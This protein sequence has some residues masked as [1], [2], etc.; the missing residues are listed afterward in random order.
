[1]SAYSKTQEDKIVSGIL[2]HAHSYG[3]QSCRFDPGVLAGLLI[4][5]CIDRFG[6][7]YSHDGVEHLPA[8]DLFGNHVVD[9]L[10]E[11]GA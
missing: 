6:D 8:L 9:I 1:M 7:R 4:A 11:V 5:N 3:G 2:K 10:S